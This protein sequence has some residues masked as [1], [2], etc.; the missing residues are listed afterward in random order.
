VAVTDEAGEQSA[1]ASDG[2]MREIAK[3]V[4]AAACWLTMA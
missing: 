2:A 3:S 4:E 1:V